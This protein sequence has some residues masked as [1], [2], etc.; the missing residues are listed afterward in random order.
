MHL[1]DQPPMERLDIL[2]VG[3]HNV[4]LKEVVGF[5]CQSARSRQ[6]RIVANANIHAL[7]LAYQLGWFRD[8]LNQCDLVFCDGFGVKWAAKILYGK[9]LQR[10]T[11]P[12]WMPLLAREFSRQNLTMYFLGAKPGVAGKAAQALQANAPGLRVVGCHHGYFDSSPH[13]R[14]QEAIIAEINRLAPHLLVLGMGM[15]A[16]EAWLRDHWQQL[17]ADVALPA[18]AMFDYLAGEV[19]RAPR[20]MTDHG[21]EWLG[22]LLI[23]PQRLWKRYL[24]GN[25]LFAWRVIRQKLGR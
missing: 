23:E 12:D 25:P 24:I 20:W 14:E 19:R 5:I 10:F 11:P 6:K 21:L 15:P 2:G 18:G 7:N 13:S 16:Q 9:S 1:I 3:I 8:F 22:R 17:Q 4:T